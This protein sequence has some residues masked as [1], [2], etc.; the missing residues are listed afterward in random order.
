MDDFDMDMSAS[1][2]PQS[3]W[4]RLSS[5][6][7]RELLRNVFDDGEWYDGPAFHQGGSYHQAL[8]EIASKLGCKTD[9]IKMYYAAWLKAK[10]FTSDQI[11]D[12]LRS[13]PK[14][15][16]FSDEPQT[17]VPIP[18]AVEV[19]P[20]NAYKQQMEKMQSEAFNDPGQFTTPGFM[21]VKPQNNN[22]PLSNSMGSMMQFMMAQQQIA[23]RQ[24]H[25]QQMMM[26]EQRRLDQQREESLRRE[27][28]ARDQQFSMQQMAFMREMLRTKDNDGF[29]DSDM[30]AI[31]KT[32]MVEQMLDGGSS[33]GGALEK[34]ADRLLDPAVLGAVASGAGAAMNR[35]QPQRPAG[36]DSPTYDPYAT[37]PSL[38]PAPA[39]APAP[40]PQPVP[41]PGAEPAPPAPAGP[42]MFF[43]EEEPTPTPSEELIDAQP[44]AQEYKDAIMLP[45]RQQLGAALDDP[46]TLEAVQAQVS[47]AVDTTLV[48]SPN[49][50]A[51]AKLEEMTRQVILIRNLRDIAQGINAASDELA[52]GTA[53]EAVYGYIV[54][55]LK[56]NPVFWDIF[57]RNSY[58]ELMAMIHPFVDTG[59]VRFDYSF[60]QKPESAQVCREII[61]RIASA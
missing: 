41:V 9:D 45:L 12:A 59:G 26:M 19:E 50:S 53:P 60:L 13:A 3:E 22:D 35:A 38:P 11:K 61:A 21:E 36:Y 16:V 4:D 42:D 5:E 46:K 29:F 48:K 25:Q 10:G 23:A 39:P 28:Q 43:G 56:Q 52:K 44:S 17:V 8:G 34:V 24:Q 6:D 47:I 40:V 2:G 55:Q 15:S 30:K 54:G 7:R 49:L 58:D 27:Q 33:G 1:D 18:E 31:F 57:S 32:K 20:S 14:T 51:E 37:G